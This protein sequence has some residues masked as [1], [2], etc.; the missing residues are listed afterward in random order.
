M[1]LRL[2]GADRT[3]GLVAA[4]LTEITGRSAV[5]AE[6]VVWRSSDLAAAWGGISAY[7]FSLKKP[8][9]FCSSLA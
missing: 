5:L 3:V 7:V 8:I 4:D 2:T 6:I 1:G 9:S